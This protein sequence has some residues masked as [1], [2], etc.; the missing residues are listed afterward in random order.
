MFL[1]YCAL[2][3]AFLGRTR[4]IEQDLT[5]LDVTWRGRPRCT[6]DRQLPNRTPTRGK[7]LGHS[8]IGGSTVVAMLLGLPILSGYSVAERLNAKLDKFIDRPA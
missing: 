6:R 5:L 4:R 8:V 2:L 7:T 1:P 3:G